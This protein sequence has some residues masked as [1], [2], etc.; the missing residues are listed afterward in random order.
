MKKYIFITVVFLISAIFNVFIRDVDF[1]VSLGAILF[2]FF[3]SMVLGLLISMFVG[4]YKE[5][6]WMK[7]WKI[8]YAFMVIASLLVYFSDFMPPNS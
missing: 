8:I 2:Q 7:Y 6:D 1:N 3:G 5:N 4:K